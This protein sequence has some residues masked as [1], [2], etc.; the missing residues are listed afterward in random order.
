MMTARLQYE[1]GT[2]LKGQQCQ[3]PWTM[4][5]DG[6]TVNAELVDEKYRC[7]FGLICKEDGICGTWNAEE[8]QFM[9]QNMMTGV[10]TEQHRESE[11]THTETQQTETQH[12]ERTAKT[13]EQRRWEEFL[14][15][16][17]AVSGTTTIIAFFVAAMLTGFCGSLVFA[18]FLV[19]RWNKRRDDEERRARVAA[20]HRSR[21]EVFGFNRNQENFAASGGAAG[22]NGGRATFAKFH[23]RNQ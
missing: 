21:D 4:T 18:S 11:T 19:Y 15:Q 7:E 14:Q 13:E 2:A 12:T 22:R 9:R 1:A 8:D 16:D 5:K 20:F 17:H 6:D 23:Y 3:Y 10:R